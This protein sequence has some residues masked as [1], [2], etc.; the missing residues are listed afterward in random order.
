MQLEE[1]KRALRRDEC[2]KESENEKNRLSIGKQAFL[3][4]VSKKF[5]SSQQPNTIATTTGSNN[6][7][8]NSSSSSSSS[9][10]GSSGSS[11]TTTK[12][13]QEMK[14]VEEISIN[15]SHQIIETT[16]VLL[17]P[18]S[19][20]N[21]SKSETFRDHSPRKQWDKNPS[22]ITETI[23]PMASL[24][25]NKSIKSDLSSNSA[26]QSLL[27]LTKPYYSRE[28]M[29]KALET[30]LSSTT[31]EPCSLKKIDTPSL[32]SDI[33]GLNTRISEIQKEISRLSFVQTDTKKS[34]TNQIKVTSVPPMSTNQ[35]AY[36]NTPKQR[37]SLSFNTENNHFDS[38]SNDIQSHTNDDQSLINDNDA[39]FIS[40]GTGAAK[41]QKPTLS[42]K[43][44]LVNVKSI[45]PTQ[46]H[47]TG[48][49]N[50]TQNQS[51]ESLLS[52]ETTPTKSTGNLNKKLIDK[53]DNHDDELQRK[54]EEFIRKQLERRQKA[55]EIRLKRE[56]ERVR[57]A[58]E[59]RLRE[60]EQA[61]KKQLEK[62]RKEAIY[63]AYQE[64]KKQLQDD[65]GG[66]IGKPRSAMQT[67]R[68]IKSSPSTQRLQNN[69]LNFDLNT[70]RSNLSKSK[71][72]MSIPFFFFS[73]FFVNY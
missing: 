13:T 47:H 53:M 25:L 18:N 38:I 41:R 29:L 7:S 4:I 20:S 23:L 63:Q 39:F 61:L 56:E 12:S 21:N 71:P 33:D 49:L 35:T 72:K 52:N 26:S 11:N 22:T 51:E 1:K 69:E 28:E 6:N 37:T 73:L 14:V 48:K 55:E 31:S 62:K 60:E 9:S 24:E 66:I 59:Q 30:K 5:D 64:K 27:D 65:S 44:P 68:T 32:N 34:I 42:D 17:S 58:E 10:S 54:K 57:L 16:A 19:S 15:S 70:E 50:R 8:S 36:L 3:Q 45:E 46:Y 43:K 67:M 2:K 40:F